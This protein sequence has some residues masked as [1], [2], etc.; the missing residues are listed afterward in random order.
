[1]TGYL[2]SAYADAL[3]EFGQPHHLAESEGW[4][5]VS[6]IGNTSGLSVH[7]ARGLYPLFTCRNWSRLSHDLKKLEDKLISLMVVTDP[8]GEF[9]PS[10]LEECFPDLFRPYKEHFVIDL[11]LPVEEKFPAHHKRNIRK[12]KKCVSVDHCNDPMKHI[13]EWTGLYSELIARNNIN[14]ISRFSASSFHKQLQVPGLDMFRASCNGETIG[15]V[16]MFVQ[17]NIAYYHLSAYSETGYRLR[18]SYSLFDYIIKYYAS[19]L[20][21][22][23]L[24]A[25]AGVYGDE[26][27]GLSRFKR[28]WATVT[29][30]AYI[31]GKIFNRAVY[32]QLA[33]SC[34][35]YGNDFFPLYR[36]KE[37]FHNGD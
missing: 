34:K 36:K 5:L 8:F 18:A 17:G 9:S 2:H 30:T 14:G 28:G 15:I 13:Q 31:C 25:G 10:G 21:W 37:V 23:N 19:R 12:G 7:D 3:S 20:K 1:M 29:R 32:E 16:L 27:D 11:T 33:S 35:P 22:I 26:N 24:G 4:I 6:R